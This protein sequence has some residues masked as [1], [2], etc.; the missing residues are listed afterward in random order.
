[1]ALDA[2]ALT[3]VQAF[4]D[5]TGLNIVAVP[6]PQVENLL[7]AAQNALEGHC[8]RLFAV[9]EYKEFYD[10]LGD[11][12]LLLHQRP[13]V[14]VYRATMSRV[15]GLSVSFAAAN[16]HHATV[17]VSENGQAVTL[18]SR[19]SAVWTRTAFDTTVATGTHETLTKLAAGIALVAGWTAS[20]VSATY[21]S[22]PS[23]DLWP[24]QAAPCLSATLTLELAGPPE[25]GYSI[26]FA[27]SEL[28]RADYWPRGYRNVLVE[29]MAGYA[30]IATAGFTTMPYDLA[31][32]CI[33]VAARI[34]G[35]GQH[36]STLKSERL[37]P[38]AWTAADG[39]NAAVLN[40]D[41]KARLVPFKETML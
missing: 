6:D 36:D 21:A 28:R 10:G 12:Y 20:V 18:S 2:F 29:Y 22:Y 31:Q 24:L 39:E 17:T 40:A 11:A 33:E 13:L 25:D 3:T 5:Y 4:R 8:R 30:P 32:V 15:I 1:M 27:A 9:R 14:E 23:S 34:Y 41:L 19:I 26:D 16:A 7:N 38:Y 37:G 35:L